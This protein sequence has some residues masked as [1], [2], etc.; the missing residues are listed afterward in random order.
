MVIQIISV[1]EDKEVEAD[2]FCKN[3]KDVFLDTFSKSLLKMRKL[4]REPEFGNVDTSD[5]EENGS[6]VKSYNEKISNQWKKWE[7]LSKEVILNNPVSMYKI[8]KK[9]KH[10]FSHHTYVGFQF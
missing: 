9:K 5:S 7:N 10:F 1:I 8:K 2:N 6:S 3:D 4:L